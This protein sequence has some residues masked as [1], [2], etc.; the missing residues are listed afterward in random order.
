LCNSHFINLKGH[1]ERPETISPFNFALN[2]VHNKVHINK[3]DL[4]KIFSRLPSSRRV[5]KLGARFG[6]PLAARAVGKKAPRSVDRGSRLTWQFSE[7]L[8]C[9]ANWKRC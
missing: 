5:L 6:F 9:A 4:Q 7:I 3:R 2:P 1:I 8:F